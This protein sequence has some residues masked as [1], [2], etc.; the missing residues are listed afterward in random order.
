MEKYD[1]NLV[2]GNLIQMEASSDDIG[3]LSKYHY[4]TLGSQPHVRAWKTVKNPHETG[5]PIGIITYAMPV[6]NSTGRRL[7]TGSFFSGS[8]KRTQLRLLNQHV[9]RIG[10]VIIDPRY[11]GI[12]LAT[13]LVAETMPKLGVAMIETTAVMGQL[14][15]FFERAGM[16]RFDLPQ[17]PEALALAQALK[18]TGINKNLWIDAAAVQKKIESL[19]QTEQSCVEKHIH[20]FMGAYGKRRTMPAGFERTR[21][22]LSRLNACPAYYIWINPKKKIEGLLL[23]SDRQME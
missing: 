21:F 2:F 5:N 19:P 20:R 6:L 15:G 23:N 22:A 14:S 10:R 9:R 11:R 13:R 1:H 4:R 18:T 7:A 16:R 3:R 17:R 12:G 8:A